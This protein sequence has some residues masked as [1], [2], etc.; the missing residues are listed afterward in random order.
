MTVLE[1]QLAGL[2]LR[3]VGADTSVTNPVAVAGV[4]R[5]GCRLLS[6][7]VPVLAGIPIAVALQRG[8]GS[9]RDMKGSAVPEA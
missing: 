4:S 3:A 7:S 9:L 1:K 5:T 8:K 2:V 6:L